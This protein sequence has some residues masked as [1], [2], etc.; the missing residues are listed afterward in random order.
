MKMKAVEG[1]ETGSIKLHKL[2]DPFFS[3][4]LTR[5]S[6][7]YASTACSGNKQDL[8]I[9][10]RPAKNGNYHLG[11]YLIILRGLEARP[12]EADKTGIEAPFLRQS[13]HRKLG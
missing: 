6:S 4:T 2:I 10:V 12:A 11:A 7:L 13:S 8:E 3:V 1:L 5:L 9:R